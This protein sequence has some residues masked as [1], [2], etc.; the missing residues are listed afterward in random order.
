MYTKPYNADPACAQIRASYDPLVPA[1]A[2]YVVLECAHFP[3]KWLMVPGFAVFK[4][5]LDTY[6]GSFHRPPNSTGRCRALAE[7]GSFREDSRLIRTSS[8]CL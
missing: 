6:R 5:H 2:W 3:P 8:F 7:A 1:K 4:S